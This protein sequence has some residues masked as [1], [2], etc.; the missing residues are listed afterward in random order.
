MDDVSSEVES[1]NEQS[2]GVAEQSKVLPTRREPILSNHLSAEE[3]SVVSNSELAIPQ[4]VYDDSGIKGHWHDTEQDLQHGANQWYANDED[5]NVQ[6]ATR[7][8]EEQMRGADDAVGE[9]HDNSPAGQTQQFKG[10]EVDGGTS[11][12]DKIN[13][14]TGTTGEIF[15]GG[16]IDPATDSSIGR[17]EST[18]NI[19]APTF[20]EVQAVTSEVSASHRDKRKAIYR[21]MGSVDEA[22]NNA[23]PQIQRAASHTEES[24][25]AA[26]SE[27]ATI[28]TDRPKSMFPGGPLAPGQ[29]IPGE[30]SSSELPTLSKKRNLPTEPDDA[31]WTRPL[32]L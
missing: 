22:G 29:F 23:I 31:G 21:E 8:A 25:T 4:L 16:S 12:R 20:S 6:T 27:D 11:S 19:E 13:I 10:D 9:V 24:D 5:D 15:P 26:V 30:Q 28:S 2:R 1:H 7:K 32:R 17:H 3:A 14:P 18:Q